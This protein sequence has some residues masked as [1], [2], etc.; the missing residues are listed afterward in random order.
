MKTFMMVALAGVALLGGCAT[1]QQGRSW[2]TL[3]EQNFAAIQPGTTGKED[4]ERL[5]GTP[6]LATVFPRLQEEVWDYRFLNGTMTYG[7]EVHF[8]TSGRTKYT[9]TYPDRCP[10]EPVACR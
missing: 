6:L 8:D 1:H 4:V 2:W 10:F 9:A 3:S 5:V 7:A